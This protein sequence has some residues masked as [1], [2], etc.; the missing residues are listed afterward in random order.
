LVGELGNTDIPLRPLG[1]NQVIE[2]IPRRLEQSK[3]LENVLTNEDR[4]TIVKY[5]D[6]VKQNYNK[7]IQLLNDI[8]FNKKAIEDAEKK[9]ATE[10]EESKL[11]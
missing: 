9:L 3:E 4:Q 7:K 2:E 6:F 11:N 5:L 8:E 1:L 10:I